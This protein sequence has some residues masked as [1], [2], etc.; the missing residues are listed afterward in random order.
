MSVPAT[1]GGRITDRLLL[2][3]AKTEFTPFEVN[4]IAID[5]K[6]LKNADAAQAYMLQG[7]LE[8]VVGNYAESKL[9]HEKSLNLRSSSAYLYNYGMSMKRAGELQHARDLFYRSFAID[10]ASELCFKHIIQINALLLSYASLEDDILRFKKSRP[11][12]DVDSI[13]YV[14]AARHTVRELDKLQISIEE[15]QRV[16]LHL[17]RALLDFGL[18]VKFV[19]ERTGEAFGSQHIYFEICVEA[20]DSQQLVKC[21]DRLLDLL[22][23]DDGLPNLEKMIVNIARVRRPEGVTNSSVALANS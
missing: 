16:G 18:F 20:K 17:E 14:L 4:A 7:M 2:L 13:P 21:N 3:A 23:E 11:E 12:V 22:L 8:A 6:R 5:I 10:S 1:N 19:V 9:Q 15:L